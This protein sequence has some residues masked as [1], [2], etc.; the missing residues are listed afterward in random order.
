MCMYITYT[1]PQS[2]DVLIM[3]QKASDADR[4]GIGLS[5]SC[6]ISVGQ[7]GDRSVFRGNNSFNVLKMKLKFD[8]PEESFKANS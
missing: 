1:H 2:V 6:F 5:T 4:E 7:R 8:L 3:V